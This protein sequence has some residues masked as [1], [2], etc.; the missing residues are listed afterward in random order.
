MRTTSRG[1]PPSGAS[2]SVD[3]HSEDRSLRSDDDD[4]DEIGSES[5]V[6]PEYP[7][8]QLVVSWNSTIKGKSCITETIL[9]GRW[10]C[11]T[12]SSGKIRKI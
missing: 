11:L 4:D 7:S 3:F 12:R 5:L 2:S 8:I 10:N 9:I 6:A 1:G